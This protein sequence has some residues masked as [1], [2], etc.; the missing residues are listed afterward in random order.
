MG[1][2]S[3]RLRVLLSLRVSKPHSILSVCATETLNHD[4]STSPSPSPT[5]LRHRQIRCTR[6][7]DTPLRL[8]LQPLHR[9]PTR[10]VR[11]RRPSPA[12]HPPA[13][14]RLPPCIN[15]R[16]LHRL[17][18]R[19][20][21]SL[22]L[23]RRSTCPAPGH[24]GPLLRRAFGGRRVPV[25][26]LLYSQLARVPASVSREF[27]VARAARGGSAQWLDPRGLGLSRRACQR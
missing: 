22:C 10:H 6:P 4:N 15:Q 27:C 25:L 2:L 19:Q 20:L 13:M 3:R 12:L 7:R 1:T 26:L 11:R 9:P 18:N 21:T 8:R 24:G 16:R 14:G 23:P 17:R 5:D